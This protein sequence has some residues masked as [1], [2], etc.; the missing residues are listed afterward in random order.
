[1]SKKFWNIA[2]PIAAVIV[3]VGLAIRFY[4][5]TPRVDGYILKNVKCE[6]DELNAIMKDCNQECRFSD[7]VTFK[8]LD[9][10]EMCYNM[11]EN[12]I[13]TLYQAC[14]KKGGLR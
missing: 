4:P 6:A 13:K 9:S 10:R 1:M 8:N 7:H 12:E 14:S 3:I 11:C 2:L 5:S